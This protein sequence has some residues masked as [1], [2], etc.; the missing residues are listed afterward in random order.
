MSSAWVAHPAS[1]DAHAIV[2]KIFILQFPRDFQS[3]ARGAIMSS[4]LRWYRS[5]VHA[6]LMFPRNAIAPGRRMD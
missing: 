3:C 5:R 1:A 2:A 4:R 6:N